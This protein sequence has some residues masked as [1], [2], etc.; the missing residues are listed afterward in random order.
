MFDDMIHG[1]GT[2]AKESVDFPWNSVDILF[3]E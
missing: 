1:Q 2:L 3:P